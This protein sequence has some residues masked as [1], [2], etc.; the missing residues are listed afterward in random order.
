[1]NV[2]EAA[3]RFVSGRYAL[4]SEARMGRVELMGAVEGSQR[5]AAAALGV[6]QRT[7]ERWR[8]GQ[9]VRMRPR[10]AAALRL[11]V[12]R[13]RLS[14]RREKRLRAAGRD[15]LAPTLTVS[16]VQHVSND[17]KL[18]GRD[19]GEGMEGAPVG[20]HLRD[21]VDRIGPVVD[22]FLSGDDEE[23]TDR[24]QALLDDYVPGDWENISGVTF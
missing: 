14:P 17:R 5:A 16:G 18:R 1:M 11:A 9:I 8:S 3:Y 2:T 21:G 15:G 6:S 24:F 4:G 23:M 12:R 13:L 7:W 10:N 19:R 22:A 20:I